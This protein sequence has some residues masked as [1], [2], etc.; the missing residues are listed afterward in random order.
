MPC[1]SFPVQCLGRCLS[2]K[3]SGWG[4]LPRFLL[5]TCDGCDWPPAL[6]RSLSPQKSGVACH[7][8]TRGCTAGT[9]PHAVETNL[10]FRS[11]LAMNCELRLGR[12]MGI[13]ASDSKERE[14]M[15]SK[16]VSLASQGCHREC[17]SAWHA[18]LTPL[19]AFIPML[20]PWSQLYLG[21]G[22]LCSGQW[23][24]QRIFLLSS[25]RIS[26]VFPCET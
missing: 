13:P 11:S 8:F 23:D 14:S 18:S 3:L 2:T 9:E 15:L 16:T 6:W 12:G 21:Q 17:L 7:L 26:P 22:L 1:F 5:Y 20:Q 19:F 10:Q 4:K 24:H 25:C